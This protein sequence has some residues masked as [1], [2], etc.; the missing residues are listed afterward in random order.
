M[1]Q[2]GLSMVLAA[3]SDLLVVAKASNSA[4]A[5]T[6]FR[7]HKPDLALMN[8]YFCGTAGIGLDAL[9]SI[10][11]E[12]PSARIVILTNVDGD[13][14]I[15]RALRAGA[16]S[17]VLKSVPKSELL[18]VIR[19]VH[20]GRKRIPADVAARLAEH[21]G[22]EDLTNREIDVLTLIRDGQSNK[23]IA[24]RLAI[25]ETTVDFHVRNLV[26]KL[27]A[28]GRTHAVTIA[29]RRGLLRLI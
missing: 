18:E 21:A 9:I 10:R 24:D 19:S 25:A 3:E 29:I 4:E 27:Q 2:E 28:N 1:F 6:E 12:F 14:E 8:Q 22:E 15:Q 11:A 5:V 13:A 17:Y 7:K 20:R 23:Q 26:G 16:A